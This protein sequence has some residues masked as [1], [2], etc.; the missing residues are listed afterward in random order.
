MLRFV[1]AA[2]PV[3][4]L[5]L[6]A[7][8]GATFGRRPSLTSQVPDSTPVRFNVPQTQPRASEAGRALGWQRGAPRVVTTRGDTVVVPEGA[9]MEVRLKERTSHA[10]T[11]AT[12]G[13]IVGLGAHYA[14]C[15]YPSTKCRELD[16]RIPV[17]TGVGALIGWRFRTDQWV[18]VRRDTVVPGS[19]PGE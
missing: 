1:S 5:L 2:S 17:G 8:G 13:W 11:G 10:G 3:L 14:A 4:F 6:A 12:I 7:C 9:R 16:L 19:R 18:R 15:N